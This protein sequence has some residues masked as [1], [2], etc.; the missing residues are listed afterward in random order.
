[1]PSLSDQPG[2]SGERAAICRHRTASGYAVAVTLSGIGPL[3]A[4]KR[5]T[6][7][8]PRAVESTTGAVAGV[9][10][11]PSAGNAVN[12]HVRLHAVATTPA[13]PLGARVDLL[14]Q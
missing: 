11:C 4:R 1:M 14:P 12:P 10:P 7:G 13:E 3:L 9:M 6:A 8:W 2:R 5:S